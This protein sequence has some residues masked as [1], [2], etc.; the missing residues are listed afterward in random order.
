MV[1]SF[2]LHSGQLN[3]ARAQPTLSETL[4]NHPRAKF[5]PDNADMTK[6]QEKLLAHDLQS[7]PAHVLENEVAVLAYILL[8]RQ[9][10]PW[11]MIPYY[12]GIVKICLRTKR[13]FD[14]EGPE[15]ACDNFKERC[16][17]F[18]FSGSQL[19]GSHYRSV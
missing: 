13:L 5:V 9:S 16:L 3:P 7:A 14:H 12:A 17:S 8:A 1:C 11:E 15:I 18:S 2:L 6:D 19:S 10:L 4:K